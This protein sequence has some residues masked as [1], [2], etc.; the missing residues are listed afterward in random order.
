MIHIIAIALLGALPSEL[1][2][3]LKL[4]MLMIL[5]K[6]SWFLL[7]VINECYYNSGCIIPNRNNEHHYL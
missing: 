1:S 2:T 6:Y 5:F 7:V 4:N 3:Y